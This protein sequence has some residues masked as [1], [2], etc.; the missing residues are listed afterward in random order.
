[1]TDLDF[2]T[3]SLNV[4]PL[5]FGQAGAFP[6]PIEGFSIDSRT[7]HPK[8]CFIAIP[9]QKF[10]GHDFIGEAF[11]KGVRCF[12]ADR[13]HKK[14]LKKEI[15]E[16]SVFLVR[17]TVESL[18]ALAH[19][20]KTS[21]FSTV[22]ALTGSSG[23]T[24]TRELIVSMLSRKYNVHTAKKN[25]NNEIGLPLTILEAPANTHIVVLE[26]G[27]NHSGEIQKLSEIAQPLLGMITN[28]GYA[29]IGHFGSLEAIAD[30]KA[31]IFRGIMPHGFAMLN[32][33]DG[34]FAYLKKR[35]P[36]ETLDFGL[37]D[38][39]VLEDKGLAGYR[40]SYQGK[41]F[42]YHLPGKHNL[43]NLSGALRVAEFFKIDLDDRIRAI[44]SVDAVSGRSEVVRKG[45]TIINDCYN[46]NPSSMAAGLEL[47][48]KSGGRR[49]AVLADMLEL[50]K[51]SH[52]L[53]AVTGELITRI[54]AA[55]AVFAYGEYSAGLIEAVKK[56]SSIPAFW[57]KTK[58]ELLKA[59]LG[60]DGVKEGDTVLVKASN[61][62]KLDEAVKILSEKF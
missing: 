16:G 22:V 37:A 54:H 21:S 5:S 6:G 14:K 13:K 53:H 35:S 58:D 56:N 3:G 24:T 31:E 12:I 59:V 33:D 38:L 2:I 40:L 32:R 28:I 11:R 8:S 50:G 18:A 25:F 51:L 49:I 36:V 61:G 44:E 17:D 57:F 60:P 39:T 23:K 42:L 4:R 26:M 9:G 45:I 29:H 43:S 41:N 10:D 48:A 34:Y 62:M 47:L 46:A 27:M 52:D 7:V 55:D 20:Y 1:M 19:Q 15:A 30:V